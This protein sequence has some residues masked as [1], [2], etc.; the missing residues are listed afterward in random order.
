MTRQHGAGHRTRL[1]VL[2][3]HPIQYFTPLYQR[4]AAAPDIELEVMF[5][6]DYGV[7]ARYDKQFG[8][9]VLWDTDLLSGYAFRFLRN[10]SPVSD[11]FNPLHAINPGAFFRVLRGFDAVWVN[12]YTYPSN[13]MGAA[14]AALRGLRLLFRSE[15]RLE[16]DRRGGPAKGLRDAVIRSWVRRADALLY[17]GQENRNA[18]LAHGARESQLFFSPYSVDV[19][20]I[21]AARPRSAEARRAL[22]ARYGLP[23]DRAIVLSVGK[24]TRRKHPEALLRI[25]ADDRL[26]GSVHV[27]FA[28]SGPEEPA[29]RADVERR[30]LANV[31]FLGF[32]NQSA[33]AE[34]HALADIFVMPSER[35]NWGLVLNEAMASGAAPVVSDDVGAAA[36]MIVPGETGITFRSGDWPA[37]V[38][39]VVRLV[40]DIGLRERMA[41]GA[42]RQSGAYSYDRSVRGILEGM[43]A[44]SPARAAG[45]RDLA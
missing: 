22:R 45:E 2:A 8:R 1:A 3:S 6:R 9:D 28:G 41:A 44:T 26:S 11:T 37:M 39:A 10:L 24:L 40:D 20:A 29:L 36:D 14:A 38:D 19:A 15:L 18:Y 35:E 32:F 31:T 16:P 7:Q 33:L 13:W 12:G 27:V 34:V 43:Q 30:A 42:K 23:T 17:I 5:Y 4:L 25:A 21:A